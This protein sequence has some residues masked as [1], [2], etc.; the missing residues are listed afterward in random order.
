MTRAETRCVINLAA[1]RNVMVINEQSAR[2]DKV[3]CL[4]LLKKI[5]H[6]EVVILNFKAK[7]TKIK[8]T[9]FR[10]CLFGTITKRLWVQIYVAELFLKTLLSAKLS[11]KTPAVII[12][13][14]SISLAT[15][16]NCQGF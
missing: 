2:W 13:T 16:T 11:L 10:D 1:C 7:M 15:E 9:Q 5:L 3:V 4:G 8:F 6:I 12:F 14:I